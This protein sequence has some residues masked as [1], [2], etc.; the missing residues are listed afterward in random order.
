MCVANLI[1]LIYILDITLYLAD[2]Y[3]LEI[4]ISVEKY[5][6][7]RNYKSRFVIPAQYIK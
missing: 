2:I 6:Y 4:H 5:I 7:Y 1:S 3:N